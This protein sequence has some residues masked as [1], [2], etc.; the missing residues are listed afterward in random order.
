MP[1]AGREDWLP[2]NCEGTETVTSERKTNVCHPTVNINQFVS[3][4]LTSGLAAGQCALAAWL[5]AL[6]RRGLLGVHGVDGRSRQSLRLLQHGGGSLREVGRVRSYG[7]GRRT[8][9]FVGQREGV[10]VAGENTWS[11][12]VATNWTHLPRKGPGAVRG[13]G[14][15]W[16]ARGGERFGL[17]GNWR[18]CRHLGQTFTRGLEVKTEIKSMRLRRNE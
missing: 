5:V 17:T 3:Q 14:E 1:P 11:P 4:S 2:V 16:R 13:F 15:G 7:G 6:P 9:L 8:L 12:Q 18:W 10:A